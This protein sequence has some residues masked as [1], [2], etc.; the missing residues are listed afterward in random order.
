MVEPLR[1]EDVDAPRA[2][3][4]DLVISAINILIARHWNGESAE[5]DVRQVEDGILGPEHEG[6]WENWWLD[7]E[8]TYRAA[9]WIVKYDDLCRL[10][11][12]EKS[13]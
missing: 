4:P 8:E 13:P 10:Y 7:F 11:T 3:F 2:Q 5:F 12:F 6:R 1:P 9:G